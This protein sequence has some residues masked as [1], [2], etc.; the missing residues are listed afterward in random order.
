VK[1]VSL[2]LGL[3][4]GALLLLGVVGLVLGLVMPGRLTLPESIPAGGKSPLSE[5]RK[6]SDLLSTQ[7]ADLL[8]RPAFPGANPLP[9]RVFV[10]RTLLF[11]PNEKESVQALRPDLVTSDG[12][13][14]DWKIKHGFDLEDSNVATQDDDS[15]GFSNKEEFD[16]GTD[17]NDSSSSPSKWVKI[18]IAGVD[19]NTLGLGL[20]GKSPDRYTLRLALPGKK[21]DVDVMVGDQ[22]WL[23]VNSKG[24]DIIKSE[25][26][27]EKIKEAG[28]C[29]HAIPILIKGYHEDKG[30]RMDEKTK[31]ENDFDDS[32][33]EIERKDGI[34][35]L[36]KI[37]IDER[38]KS[39]GVVWPVG[40]IRLVSMV[41]G[42]GELGPYRV[43][44]TISYSGKKFVIRDATSSKVSLWMQPEGEEVQIL[45][46]TP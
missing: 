9:H 24:L 22:L 36:F 29:P 33:L 10:S 28:A 45:P 13:N 20:A 4:T 26:E 1:K 15:D 42:E 43:G 31:T 14:V 11:L 34:S 5:I 38:G 44:Q 27:W 35:G 37:L 8:E 39:R 46:K 16:K 19:T 7:L 2:W 30:K 23:A 17:P 21:K 3:G 18:K 25:S 12:I 32:Y 40:D 6:K 41:P